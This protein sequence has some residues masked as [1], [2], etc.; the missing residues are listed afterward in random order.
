[1]PISWRRLAV[2][3][4]AGV[5]TTL[6]FASPALACHP[7]FEGSAQAECV[8]DATGK[9][10]WT[11]SPDPKGATLTN[12]T[13]T[14]DN[15]EVEGTVIAGDTGKKISKGDPLPDFSKFSVAVTNKNE[16]AKV[17]I[18]V[19]GKD[20]PPGGLSDAIDL[21]IIDW[22][23]C[24]AASPSPSPSASSS[25]SSAAA[26]PV[27]GASTGVLVGVAVVLLT[28]GAALFL[29]ARRRR[30]GFASD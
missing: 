8:T 25:S 3:G 20:L 15:K 28:V 2:A 23:K 11:V 13:F 30:V 4:I 6:A 14:V 18:E 1:M 29:I 17:W 24:P 10:T 12:Y 5:A 7:V 27:T 9:V 26:L 21:K 16:T 22:T 19:A